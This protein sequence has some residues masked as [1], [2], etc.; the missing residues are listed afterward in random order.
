MWKQ[1]TLFTEQFLEHVLFIFF[2]VI[3][4]PKTQSRSKASGFNY[5][6]KKA[7]KTITS[8]TEL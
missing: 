8:D 6:Y 3:L 4:Q 1:I 2:I 5:K 7:L